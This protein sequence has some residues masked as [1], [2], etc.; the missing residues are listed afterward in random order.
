MGTAAYIAPEILKPTTV[1]YSQ[2]HIACMKRVCG[3][4]MYQVFVIDI[5][6][7]EEGRMRE[8]GGREGGGRER[9]F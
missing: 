2:V 1:R 8:E 5:V 6:V 3:L 7:D 9:Y 4:Y